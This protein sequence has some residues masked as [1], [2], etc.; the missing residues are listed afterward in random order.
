MWRAAASVKETD[1]PCAPASAEASGGKGA[2]PG[3]LVHDPEA[4]PAVDSSDIFGL[5][6]VDSGLDRVFGQDGAV[7][8]DGRQRQL[9]GDL[10]VLDGECFVERLATHPFGHQRAGGN[11]RAAAVGL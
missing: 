8:L 4:A 10:G 9:F 2:S 1:M 7:D 6:V 5:V 3:P 11:G